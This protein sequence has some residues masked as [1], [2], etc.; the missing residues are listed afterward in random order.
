LFK[1]LSGLKVLI[2]DDQ[3]INRDGIEL[4]FKLEKGIEVVGKQH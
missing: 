4:L 3:A 2:C 1:I